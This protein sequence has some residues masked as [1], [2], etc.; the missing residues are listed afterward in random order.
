MLHKEATIKYKGYDPTLLKPKSQKRVCRV[1]DIC[2]NISYVVMAYYSDICVS[3]ARKISKNIDE[4]NGMYGTTGEKSTMWGK[5]HTP[6]TKLKISIANKGKLTG[7]KNPAKRVEV[8][9]KISETK[10]GVPRPN[11]TGANS[12]CFIAER[13]TFLDENQGK[14]FCKYCGGQIDIKIWH[15]TYGIPNYCSKECRGKDGVGDKNPNWKGGISSEPYCFKFNY[16]VKEEVRDRHNRMCC[17]CGKSEKESGEKLCVHHIDYNKNQGCDDHKWML[18]P[19]CRICHS[20][21]NSNRD[22]WEKH[23]MGVLS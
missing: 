6:E 21:T 8:R 4:S 3:C 19:L 23:L 13:H 5:T 22:Y 20:K 14:Y 12:P 15:Y 17:I 11:M 1:C 16:K 9:Q 7:D 18:I 2:G 10:K